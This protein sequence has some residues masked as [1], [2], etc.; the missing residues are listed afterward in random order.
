M[1]GI[2]GQNTCL[3]FFAKSKVHYDEESSDPRHT[4]Y[5]LATDASAERSDG[6]A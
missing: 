6:R 3:E 5:L 1:A 4:N 2:A